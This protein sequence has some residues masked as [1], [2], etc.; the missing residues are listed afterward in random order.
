MRDLE[1]GGYAALD[2]FTQIRVAITQ[3]RDW[4]ARPVFLA[5][6]QTLELPETSHLPH[7]EVS[8]TFDPDGTEHWWD[9]TTGNE[10]PTAPAPGE[11]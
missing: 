6:E 11:E 7:R 2:P 1:P 4:W 9:P 5:V 3:G 8:V 10:L